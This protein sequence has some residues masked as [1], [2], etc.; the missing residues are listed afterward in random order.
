ML[1]MTTIVSFVAIFIPAIAS[2]IVLKRYFK[3]SKMNHLKM[4]GRFYLG[5]GEL[6]SDLR[7]RYRLITDP[8]M[9]ETAD[10]RQQ[11]L[12]RRLKFWDT[13]GYVLALVWFLA[14]VSFG[15]TIQR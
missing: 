13:C 8:T 11:G 6:K 7:F 9:I 12:M 4:G 14:M 10:V 3:V 15:M 2:Y 1:A 5:F